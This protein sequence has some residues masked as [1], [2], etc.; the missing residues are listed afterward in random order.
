[1]PHPCDHGRAPAASNVL[2]DDQTPAIRHY[3]RL[4]RPLTLRRVRHGPRSQI[5]FPAQ[6]G[7]SLIARR[8]A[9]SRSFGRA[10]S[11][12]AAWSTCRDAL[13]RSRKCGAT[14]RRARTRVAIQIHVLRH[15]MRSYGGRQQ[16][17]AR[18]APSTQL[19][20]LVSCSDKLLRSL[21]PPHPFHTRRVSSAREN[22]Q[23]YV[24]TQNAHAWAESDHS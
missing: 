6:C 7:R 13:L 23:L 11:D 16:G 3:L 1:M 4:L 19:H 9:R 8:Q 2:S 20:A 18:L 24:Q 12:T 5:L 21:T 15:A 17:T 10:Q 22:G 14:H